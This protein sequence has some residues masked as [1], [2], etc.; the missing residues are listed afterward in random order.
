M[1]IRCPDCGRDNRDT[2]NF[3]IGCGRRDL[4]MLA[5]VARAQVS[6]ATPPVQ[7]LAPG[8]PAALGPRPSAALAPQVPPAAKPAAG[9]HHWL[10]A[11]TPILEGVV[12]IHNQDEVYPPPDRALTLAKIGIGLAVLPLALYFFAGLGILIIVIIALGGGVILAIFGALIG[13]FTKLFSLIMPRRRPDDRKLTQ[14]HLVVQAHDGTQSA[15]LLYG[16]H[17]AGLLHKGDIVRVYGRRR[18]NGVVRATRVEVVGMQFAP[19]MVLQR[20]VYGKPPFPQSVAMCAW[21]V[22]LIA[23]A[24]LYLP[25]LLQLI[26]H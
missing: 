26:Q 6:Q 21:L 3:C 1:P 16:D 11:R 4:Q 5:M 18:R 25:P 17:I 7:P 14:V 10:P 13:A 22:A 12:E 23:W 20:T 8:S 9:R 15:V 24:V 2:A 19:G